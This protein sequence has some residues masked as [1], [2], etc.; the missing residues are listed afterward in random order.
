VVGYA[1]E[2]AVYWWDAVA[3]EWERVGSERIELDNSVA[4]AVEQF[5]IYALMGGEP[6]RLYLP[7]VLR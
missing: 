7:L 5:G 4:A 1:S 2:L 3:G 6:L